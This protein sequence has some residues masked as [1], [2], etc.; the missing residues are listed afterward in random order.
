MITQIEVVSSDESLL[1]QGKLNSNGNEY[2]MVV[3]KASLPDGGTARDLYV[4]V[5]TLFENDKS[6]NEKSPDFSGPIELPNQEKRRL[7][8][9]KTVSND[10]NT[11]FLSARIGDKTPRVGE[12]TVSI[13]N[14]DDMEVIDEVPF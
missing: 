11:K 9:W 8:C 12:D 2:R 5:G 3:V 13:S 7:A 14:N 1:V 4:K 10:G 6:Q